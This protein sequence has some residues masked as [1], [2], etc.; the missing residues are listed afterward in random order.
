MGWLKIMGLCAVAGTLAIAV[1]IARNELSCMRPQDSSA[2]RYTPLLPAASR[3]DAVNTFLT[4]PEWSIVHAYEDFAAVTRQKGEENFGYLQ[5]ITG[6]WSS[7]CSLSQVAS[8][9]GEISGEIKAMLYIIGVSFTGEMAVKG[10]YETTIGRMTAWLRGPERTADDNFAL[11]TADDYAAFLRQT[12]WYEFPFWTVLKAYWTTSGQGASS[13]VRTAERRFALSM[14]YGVKGLYARVI[15]A[16]AAAAPARLTIVSVVTGVSRQQLENDRDVKI[17]REIPEGI[18]TETPRYRAY[19]EFLQRVAVAG[20]TI[21]EI[22]GNDRIFVTVTGEPRQRDWTQHRANPMF[23]VPLQGR[24]G[25]ER[26]GL[27]LPVADLAA[28][29]RA[30]PALGLAFEH[31]YDY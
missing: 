22:A 7:L 20:G 3:R 26:L 25:V 18:I 24:P 4:Y 19:T 12:P 23:M 6:F 11:K 2:A 31:A 1:P 9:R 27:E 13:H 17:L 14:E 16:M 29:M 15:G 30:A 5:S 21:R 8:R 10:A 28:F